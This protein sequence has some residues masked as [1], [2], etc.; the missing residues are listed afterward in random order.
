MTKPPFMTKAKNERAASSRRLRFTGSS[1]DK[2]VRLDRFLANAAPELSRNRLKQLIE[3]GQ[4]STSGRTITDP[5]Y[6]VKPGET[7]TLTVPEVEPA[8]PEAQAIPL[9]VLYEDADLLVV[10]KPAGLVVHPAPGNPD[11][12]LVNALI[13]HCGESLSGI[14]GVARPGIVHRLDKDTSGLLIAAKNDIAHRAL[15]GQLSSRKLKRVYLALVFGVPVPASGKIDRPIGRHPKHRKKMAVL[16]SGG[17]AAQTRYRVVRRF[18]QWLSLVECQLMTGRTHQIR[19]HLAHL[20]HPLVGD[21]VYGRRRL[22][23]NLPE[24]VAQAIKAFPRQALHAHMIGFDHPRSEKR[25]DLES[26]LPKDF[27]DLMQSLEIL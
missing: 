14:G 7:F 16:R 26:A 18:G 9:S 19:V 11:L 2:G 8:T 3:A 21:P 27:A 10:D 24:S 6:R 22:A 15:S 13:H 20:G 4:L 25:L 17:R 5:S 12:T 1:R 23:A